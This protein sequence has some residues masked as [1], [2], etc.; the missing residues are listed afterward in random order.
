MEKTIGYITDLHIDEAF[1]ITHGVEARKNWG[2]ILSDLAEKQIGN[3]ILGGDIGE[4]ASN[5]WLFQSL[6]AAGETVAITLGNHDTFWEVKKHH[7]INSVSNEGELYRSEE[8]EHHTYFFLDSSSGKMSTAQLEWL[9]EGLLRTTKNV[10]VFIHHP[11]LGVHT[12]I[13][14]QY[15]LTNRDKVK[16]LLFRHKK[17]V[18]IFCGHYHMEDFAE[19]TNIRQYITPAASY[20]VVKKAKG[21]EIDAG[22]FG[23]RIIR[24]VE[25]RIETEVVVMAK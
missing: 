22:T 17:D 18:V 11:I 2:R 4:P 3:I 8:D 5:E 12:P 16:E 6:D 20:Q 19:D 7:K 23:Y 9:S 14:R 21:I 13:D 10:V 25:G 1:P 24:F 15:P